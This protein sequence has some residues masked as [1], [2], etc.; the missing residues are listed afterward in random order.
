MSGGVETGSVTVD[1]VATFLRRVPGE[2]PPTVFVHGVPTH[3]GDWTPFLERAA[4]P[5]LAF[6]LPGFGRS[7]RPPPQRFDSTMGSYADFVERLLDQV[8]VGEYSLVVHDWGAVALIAAQRHPERLRRLCV[9]NTVPLLP[10]YR[11]HRTAR[12]WRTPRVGEMV[13][14]WWSPRLLS[15]ALRESRA[16]WSAPSP[17][18]VEMVASGLDRGTFDAILRLY[19]SADPD[20]LAHAGRHLDSIR[21]PAL[22]VWGMR[23]RYIP[24]RFGRDYAAALPNA[25]LIELERAGHWPWWGEAPELVDRVTEFV[26]GC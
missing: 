10:G 13:T 6:D 19:R 25:E 11:W 22:V 1:G 24:G 14:R 20:E 21:A 8:G 15:I 17:E 2:G 7:E 3:S 16:D 23:D 12:Q 18:F 26:E 4:G 9:I 5:A